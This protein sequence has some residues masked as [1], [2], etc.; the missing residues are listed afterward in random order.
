MRCLLLLL[1]LLPEVKARA[2]V[3]LFIEDPINFLGPA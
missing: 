3:V 2:D 1:L